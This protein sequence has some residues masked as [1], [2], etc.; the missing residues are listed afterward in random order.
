MSIPRLP[1]L[2]YLLLAFS[3]AVHAGDDTTLPPPDL[4]R[5]IQCEGDMDSFQALN[6]PVESPLQAVSL[7]WT[8]LP[9]TNPFMAEFRLNQALPVFGRQID[10]F[11]VSGGTVMAILDAGTSSP[12]SLAEQL[13]LEVALDEDGKFMAGRE[14][15]SRDLVEPASGQAIIESAVLGVS[16]VST[17]PGKVLAGCTYSLDLPEDEEEE[18]GD[19]PTPPS[20]SITAPAA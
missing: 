15:T 8:P 5:L 16:T 11:L 3:G 17:H 14:V 7:G 19:G 1:A 9:R 10:H 13:S 20:P 6:G 4:V 2:P 18:D 12:R